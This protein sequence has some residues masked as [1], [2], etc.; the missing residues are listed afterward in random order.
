MSLK[1]RANAK[2]TGK[3]S[4]EVTVEGGWKGED[5]GTFTWANV[6]GIPSDTQIRSLISHTGADPDDYEWWPTKVLFAE[7]SAAWLRD[8]EDRGEKHTAYTGTAK[9]GSV[10]IAIRR[11]P[12]PPPELHS[13]P[14]VPVRTHP[15]TCATCRRGFSTK[16]VGTLYCSAGCRDA[17]APGPVSTMRHVI[18]P[19]TQ[20]RPGE[21]TDHLV[22]A[23]RWIK[24]HC[25][26]RPTRIIHLG[27]HWDMPSV[28]TH[29]RGKM[30][31]EGRRIA[32][33]LAA[34][35]RAFEVLDEAMGSTPVAAD[36]VP[37][38]TKEYLPGNHEDR[39]T[40]YVEEHSELEGFLSV[41]NCLTP[42]EW[43]RH[44][45]LAPVE[46]EGIFYAHYFYQPNT[47]RPYS[48]ENIENRIK[49]VGQSFVMGHQQGL[50]LGMTYDLTGGHR[51][52]VVAGSFYQHDEDYKGPQGNHHWRGI[53]VLNEVA[54][55]SADPMPLS[56]DYLCRTYTGHPI[57]EH[58]GVCV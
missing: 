20:V 49:N 37:W 24:E 39:I 34:G 4:D 54:N 38:W 53:V 33:D 42:E 56:L 1:D 52:G 26:D 7:N 46:L 31:A 14:A 2:A 41:A 36:G 18:I 45:Y 29:D 32:D 9:R 27:D 23:G 57:S 40:R 48:G 15:H 16:R 11:K 6:S 17:Q 30:K 3:P 55:G 5:E 22:W 44:E 47:G 50:R 28:S 12:T 19:D 58:V 10:T 25:Q 21:P 35:N 13:L 8:P 51:I 43:R